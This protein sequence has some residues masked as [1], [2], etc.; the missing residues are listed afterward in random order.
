[1]KSRKTTADRPEKGEK[2]V[3]GKTAGTSRKRPSTLPFL[4]YVVVS[5][6]LSGL[7]AGEKPRGSDPDDQSTLTE[8]MRKKALEDKKRKL[9]EQVA[10]LLASKKAKL[11]KEFPP[12]P[13]ESDIDMG[14]F[15]EGRG[16]LL[17]EIFAASAPTG[18]K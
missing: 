4:D 10:A 18:I 14:I 8:M 15:S 16:N 13:S 2:R 7:G 5:D 1:M 9:D 12:A 17:E 3:E 11:H 6:T